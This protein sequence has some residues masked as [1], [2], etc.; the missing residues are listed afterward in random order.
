MVSV[1]AVVG[2]GANLGDRLATLR[3]AAGELGRASSVVARSRVYE[4]EPVG[5]AQ[6]R[7]LNAAVLVDWRGSPEDLLRELL[8]VE[9]RLGRVRGGERWS[10]RA[11]DLDLLWAEGVVAEGAHLTVPHPR[12][13]ERAFALV[14]LLDVAPDARDPRTGEAYEQVL[15]ALARVAGDVRATGESL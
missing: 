7:F 3:A 14:P 10:P 6:P 11:I 4:T 15:G 8:D 1:R 12:L 13:R 2:L 9:A 5:P